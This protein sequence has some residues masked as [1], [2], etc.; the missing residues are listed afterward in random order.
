MPT[1][2]NVESQPQICKSSANNIS[3]RDWITS[4]AATLALLGISPVLARQSET[5]TA[6]NIHAGFPSQDPQR[7]QAVVRFCH[8]DFDKVR[9]L[10]SASPELAKATWDWGFGDWESAIGAASHM[11]RRDIAQ[12]LIDH[13]A[14]PTLFTHAMMGNLAVVKATIEAMPGIQK[15]R[16]PHGFTLLSHAQFGKE[17]AAGVVEY[18]EAVGDADQGAT[19]LE[20]SESQ[21]E[22]YLGKYRYGDNADEVVDIIRDRRGNLALQRSKQPPR[23]LNRVEENGF[24]PTGAPS[25]RIR[26]QVDGGTAKTIT[27]HDPDP[28]LTAK[29]I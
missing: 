3:R 29:K 20:I 11:G 9:E 13:G 21:Q 15:I 14:R 23:T 7:V 27:V 5:V 16:G 17:Q 10:V 19:R 6:T 26:F 4:A 8:F 12:F 2:Q 18:L 1:A 22:I 25:V 28:I 24:A